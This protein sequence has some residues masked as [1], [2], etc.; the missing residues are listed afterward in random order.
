MISQ[1]LIFL[2]QVLID[3]KDVKDYNLKWLRQH[4]GVVSQE[5][6]LFQL[7]IEENIRYGKEG[8]TMDDIIKAAQMAN[9]HDFI[10]K[11]PEVCLSSSVDE[12]INVQ[13][14]EVSQQPKYENQYLRAIT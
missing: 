12:S 9:A 7:T 2:L 13:V 10:S 11:L 1:P 8:V 4:I 6:V 3:G 5:P 14:L